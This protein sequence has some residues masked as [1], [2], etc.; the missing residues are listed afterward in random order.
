[1][2]RIYLK[3]CN[4]DLD[5]AENGQIA[6]DKVLAHHPDLILMDLAMPVMD[7]FEATRAIRRWEEG[8]NRPPIPIL[9]V[10]ASGAAKGAGGSL[11]AGCNEHLEKPIARSVLL[12][13]IYRYIG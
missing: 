3:T 10:S 11:E 7:G 13:A 12:D 6:F 9:A 1:M 4:F 8:T 2:I 5:Y